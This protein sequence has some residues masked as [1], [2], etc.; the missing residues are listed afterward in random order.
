V[1]RSPVQ[2]VP[3]TRAAK[4][5]VQTPPGSSRTRPVI[6]AASRD[7]R[8]ATRS[9]TPAALAK[10][11]STIVSVRVFRAD[12]GTMEVVSVTVT[13]G[14]TALARMPNWLIMAASARV[15]PTIPAR[16]AG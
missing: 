13:A 6:S 7:S 4:P 12:S 2:H 14:A 1:A 9:A 3:A 10:R 8:N 11:R 16:A 15:N 5:H